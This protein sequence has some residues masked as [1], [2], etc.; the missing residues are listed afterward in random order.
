MLGGLNF[1]GWSLIVGT[2]GAVSAGSYGAI[3]YFEKER[4]LNGFLDSW[5][6]KITNDK[7]ISGE[8]IKR[9]YQVDGGKKGDCRKWENKTLT[10]VG[11]EECNRRIQEKWGQPQSKQ[12]EIWFNADSSNIEEVVKS[13][14]QEDKSHSPNLTGVSFSSQTFEVGGLKCERKNSSDSS[15]IEISCFNKNEKSDEDQQIN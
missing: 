6:V 9:E 10:V 2:A 13:H 1:Y 15:N 5:N 12:P 4:K 8:Y 14:F 11:L 3:S 7:I